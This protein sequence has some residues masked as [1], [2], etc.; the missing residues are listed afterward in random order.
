MGESHS[1]R[2]EIKAEKGSTISGISQIINN[3]YQRSELEE[4][5][6][7]IKS[8]IARYELGMIQLNSS[9]HIPSLPYKGLY[10]FEIEDKGIFFGREMDIESL[11]QVLCSHRITILHAESGAGKT[12]LLKA[13]IS[14]VLIQNSRLPVYVRSR[15][16]P[17]IAIKKAIAP[18]STPWPRLMNE[19]SLH[20]FLG[21]VCAH[22]S[23]NIEDLVI[24]LDQFEE[25]FIFSTSPFAEVL[26][27]CYNDHE[28]PLKIIIS[29]RK[30]YLS[31]LAGFKQYIPTI[32]YNDYW[33]KKMGK[34]ELES[35]IL[36]PIISMHEQSIHNITFD[37]ALLNKIITLTPVFRE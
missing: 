13:G 32:F 16:D 31:D 12:S 34:N 8:A 25:Y 10:A 35:A 23:R 4:V 30:D 28:L 1:N 3:I 18:P 37:P 36:K 21:I 20:E 22:M 7:Y 11:Y 27:D 17:V 19:L 26:A 29:L 15:E 5:T 14:P 9:S 33:L 2:Q 6:E 24:I